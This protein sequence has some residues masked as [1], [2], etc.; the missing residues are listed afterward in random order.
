MTFNERKKQLKKY[1]QEGG[2][3][4]FEEETEEQAIFGNVFGYKGEV[5]YDWQPHEPKF[6]D[7]YRSTLCTNFSYTNCHETMAKKDDIKDPDGNELNLS[8]K[9]SAFI[10]GTSQR[11]NGLET[12]AYTGHKKGL[13]LEKEC[14]LKELWLQNQWKYWKEI[15]DVSGVSPNAKLYKGANYS[16]V[17]P[18][19][20][21]MKQA[22]AY[23]PLFVGAYVGM[24]WENNIARPPRKGE[25]RSGHA[26][27]ISYISDYIYVLDSLG[28]PNKKL[29]LNYPIFIAKS[30]R[31]LPS[32]WKQLN[33][34]K[35]MILKRTEKKVYGIIN[36][37]KYWLVS[38]ADV[39]AMTDYTSIQE[40]DKNILEVTK[41][42]LD[43]YQDAGVIGNPSIMDFIFGGRTK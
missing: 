19:I 23:S 33:S 16:K 22:L 14:P 10:S 40:A 13:V 34:K 15:T 38:W 24:G 28:R 32:N 27:Q 42:H 2:S 17:H 12:V 39:L 18:T 11:G 9:W 25:A 6:E 1:I 5:P 36:G 7:Q 43:T 4:V 35:K 21:G 20:S 31:E 29:P 30:F 3:V 41:E 26:F 8:D 37:K